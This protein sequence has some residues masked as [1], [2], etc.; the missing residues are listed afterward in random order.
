MSRPGAEAEATRDDEELRHHGC[1]RSQQCSKLPQHVGACNRCRYSA[2]TASCSHNNL[3][4][5]N[6][7]PV[8]KRFAALH[9]IVTRSSATPCCCCQGTRARPLAAEE[10]AQAA[11]G[12]A[13]S[14]AAGC[15]A[16]ST[17]STGQS[18][19]SGK[20]WSL[21][22]LCWWR[23]PLS[24]CPCN[25]FTYGNMP[26]IAPCCFGAAAAALVIMTHLVRDSQVQ[27]RQQQRGVASELVLQ[28]GPTDSPQRSPQHHVQQQ[29]QQQQRQRPAALQQPHPQQPTAPDSVEVHVA[30]APT[31]QLMRLQLCPGAVSLFVRC[32]ISLA[33]CIPR[34]HRC[35][36]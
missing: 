6:A 9:L 4:D 15:G 25:G 32:L 26:N 17:C 20:R 19:A 36:R 18:G 16:A 35:T 8:T 22:L 29:Q 2:G 30:V 33:D 23:R 1:V 28:G 7:D 13:G 24:S 34:T 27:P 31:A 11:Q 14:R 3:H 5:D 12:A 21:Q 10:A